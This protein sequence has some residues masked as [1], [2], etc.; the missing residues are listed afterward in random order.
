MEVTIELTD[1]EYRSII[2]NRIIQWNA[3]IN[4][5]KTK[6]NYKKYHNAR[7]LSID[8][9]ERC[10]DRILVHLVIG[11]TQ[12]GKTGSMLQIMKRYIK[13]F[14]ISP[15]NIYVITGLSSK[16]W[17][18]QTES[19]LPKGTNVYHNGELKY[20]K[21]DIN[22]KKNVLILIDEI[23]MAA[24]T[25]NTI[26]KIFK[27]L[28]I[29]KEFMIENNYT[30]VLMSATPDGILSTIKEWSDDEYALHMLEPG[31]GYFG[32]KEMLENGQLIQTEEL[33]IMKEGV[34]SLDKKTTNFWRKIIT[35][36]LTF[37]VPK[38]MLIRI[39]PGQDPN[40]YMEL[41]ESVLKEYFIKDKEKFSPTFTTHFEKDKENIDDILSI[42]PKKHTL[43][44]VYEKIKC[45]ITISKTNI[46]SMVDRTTLND[47]CAIQSFVGR[48]CGYVPHKAFIYTNM[49]SVKIYHTLIDSA[50]TAEVKWK[51][52]TTKL[53]KGKT[54]A[55]EN[56]TSDMVDSNEDEIVS[57][58]RVPI[59]INIKPWGDINKKEK[60]IYIL[61]HITDA[62]LRT[63]IENNKCKQI[64]IPDSEGSYKKHI[65]DIYKHYE[66]KTTTMIDLTAD[67]KTENNWQ[68]FYDNKQEKCIILVWSLNDDY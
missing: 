28:G 10:K 9:I 59:V 50:F 63:F 39:K 5:M 67:D 31:E 66:N 42:E 26:C 7:I 25:T 61:R 32:S 33:F 48:G 52:N 65:T 3:E 47:S 49:E 68:A 21:K 8:V 19:R 36:H 43:L 29:D 30:F 23:A 45:S 62:K 51:S 17:K 16:S 14:K 24:L 58:E 34:M 27:E 53:V 57:Y 64:S 12:S 55:R 1:E 60:I 38:H 18:E 2:K 22:G 11:L 41:L 20:M 6:K 4:I 37:D 56:Y 46:G 40:Q 44:F 35:N 15:D 13:T 54:E